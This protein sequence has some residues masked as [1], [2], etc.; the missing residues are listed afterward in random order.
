MKKTTRGIFLTLINAI[1][2]TALKIK[3]I[4]TIIVSIKQQE[5][6]DY[7][8]KAELKNIGLRR[9]LIRN[10]AGLYFGNRVET[11]ESLITAFY[12]RC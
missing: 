10:K 4:T 3:V 9:Q 6:T 11:N 5:K 12:L 1:T 2:V 8:G 7:H